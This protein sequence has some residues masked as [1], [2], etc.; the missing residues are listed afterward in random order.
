MTTKATSQA[1]P[2]PLTLHSLWKRVEN[3]TWKRDPVVRIKAGEILTI[4]YCGEHRLDLEKFK[5]ILLVCCV[6]P[7]IW[8]WSS[9]HSFLFSPPLSFQCFMPFLEYSFQK[10]PC[11]GSLG[12]GWACGSPWPFLSEA[13]PAAPL[14]APGQLPLAQESYLSISLPDI[15]I[16]G[17][18]MLPIW[19]WAGF[20]FGNAPRYIYPF[21]F[22]FFS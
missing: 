12:L 14:S 21:F 6:I 7:L 9:S 8:H 1:P 4:S 13:A 20:C 2:N 15:E 10:V 5:L 18:T 16:C 19:N 3:R 11:G 17:C 22:S